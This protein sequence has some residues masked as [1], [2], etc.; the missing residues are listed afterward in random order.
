MRNLGRLIA[1]LMLSSVPFLPIG[2]QGSADSAEVSK[3]NLQTPSPHS[4][5]RHFVFTYEV[6]LNGLPEKG[7]KVEIWVPLP[8]NTGEQRLVSTKI[9]SPILGETSEDPLN[10]NNYWHSSPD[11]LP[12]GEIRLKFEFEIVRAESHPFSHR[13]SPT[14]SE[15]QLGQFLKP[16]TLIPIT[17]RFKT[18]ALAQ[19]GNRRNTL[20]MARALYDYV[21]S[22]MTYDKTGEGWGRGDAN[23]ACD[24]GK[25]N[26]T[27]YH[28]FFIA[29][30]RSIG[31]PARFIIGF[32]LPEKRGSGEV[33][34]YHC[35]AEFYAD[36]VGWVPV[37]I[38]E[39]DKHPEKSDYYFGNLDEN[40]LH[41][42]TG[43]DITLSPPQK[44]KPLNFFIYP[45]V[46]VDGKEW[47][48]VDYRFSYKD[49]EN[50]DN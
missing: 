36:G 27:D 11:K 20:E 1:L 35:W 33:P 42:T 24:V 16:E 2:N 22:A 49:L 4:S 50:L 9:T 15:E 5:V 46:E 34:G 8:K 3:E 47:S 37:D 38:S 21:I 19:A 18:I 32:P 13:A 23:Y 41:F 30:S 45:Y 17:E 25:G 12:N 7:E 31:I 26:C 39:A 29:L 43:R 28:S 40:R 48:H 6:S 10:G 44:G 14:L